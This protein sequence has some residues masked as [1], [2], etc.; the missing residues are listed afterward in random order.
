M[1][2]VS[3]NIIKL[4]SSSFKLISQKETCDEFITE[5]QINTL[6]LSLLEIDVIDKI[7]ARDQ[8]AIYFFETDNAESIDYLSINVNSW[9]DFVY[10]LQAKNIQQGK[11]KIQIEKKRYV[12]DI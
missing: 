11:I 12:I 3:N 5:Y 10:E 8:I 4:F 1:N 7:N 6:S 2:D 9:N